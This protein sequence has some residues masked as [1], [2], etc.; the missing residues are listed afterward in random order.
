MVTC[1]DGYRCAKGA[2]R[3][4][5]D[6]R[7]RVFRGRHGRGDGLTLIAPPV[8]VLHCRSVPEYFALMSPR[9]RA[10]SSV[11]GDVADQGLCRS[12]SGSGRRIGTDLFTAQARSFSGSAAAR[13]CRFHG[14]GDRCVF[15]IGEVLSSIEAGD[16]AE[17]LPVPVASETCANMKS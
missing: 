15:A 9:P 8:A 3:G 7:N 2:P 10:R 11:V 1:L 17:V 14:C 5:R 6:R 13:R 12:C 4:A 16:D